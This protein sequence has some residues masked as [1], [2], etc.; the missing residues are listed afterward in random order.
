M[1]KRGMTCKHWP[2]ERGVI[3]VQKKLLDWQP[4]K[5]QN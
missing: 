5:T 4:E 2:R 3:K 1:L